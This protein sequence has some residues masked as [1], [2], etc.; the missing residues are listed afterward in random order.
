MPMTTYAT[1]PSAGIREAFLA[2]SNSVIAVALPWDTVVGMA[3]ALTYRHPD[4]P[5]QMLSM[6]SG[7]HPLPPAGHRDGPGLVPAR[8][9]PA[10]SA[11]RSG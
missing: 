1:H 9:P 5:L 7:W 10:I 11:V 2:D 4:K 8:R 6:K 3:S